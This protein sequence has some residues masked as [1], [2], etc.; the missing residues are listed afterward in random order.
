LIG[1]GLAG[2]LVQLIGAPLA[3]VA[4][5]CSY[6]VSGA[7]L[8]R[9]RAP[10]RPATH[11]GVETSLRRAIGEG[12]RWVLGH[13]LLRPLVGATALFVFANSVLEAVFL[14]YLVGEL[15]LTP[16]AIGTIYALGSAGFLLGALATERLTARLGLGPTLIAT[17]TLIAL[18]DLIAPLARGPM[19]V[20]G[21]LIVVT[22]VSFGAGLTVFN[23]N[24]VSLRQGLTPDR[25]QGR[26]NASVRLLVQGLTPLGAIGGGLLG[27]W[28]GLRA[29]LFIAIAGEFA[30]A[31]WLLFSPI[32]R[33]RHL[34]LPE[35][36]P[37][38]PLAA[39]AND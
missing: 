21:A 24:A 29:T 37:G 27:E 32:R 35:S 33:E 6:L 25:L 26:T 8:T 31:A 9:I 20:V 5:A 38:S 30:A 36:D 4:D 10:E 12:L 16:V 39:L 1:P 23:I 34:T 18:S 3:I 17:L 11:A 19:L 15:A 22:Q 2:G 7:L 13:R 28:L 14:L